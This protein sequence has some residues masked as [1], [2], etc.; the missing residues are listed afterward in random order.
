MTR[1][2]IQTSIVLS[3]LLACHAATAVV[4]EVTY[5]E[6]DIVRAVLSE[7]DA[8][9]DRVY[10][11]RFDEDGEAKIIFGDGV[12]GAR[13]PTGASN[14]V[15][16]YRFGGGIGGD[17][18]NEYELSNTVFPF[19]PI[20]DFLD[21]D[22]GKLDASF[23][24]LGFT[25]LTL[26]FSGDGLR[27]VDAEVTRVPEPGTLTLLGIGLFGMGLARRRKKATLI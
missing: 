21:E 7:I 27:V 22:T 4:I 19:I 3:A 20:S 13:L 11:I 25:S 10:T 26:E 9:D 14:V 12:H 23:I 5:P 18:V 24:L 15:A 2:L 1:R 16:S 8:V 17:I 6:Q